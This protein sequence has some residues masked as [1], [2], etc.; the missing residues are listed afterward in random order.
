MRIEEH[1]L[2]GLPPGKVHDLDLRPSGEWVALVR[3]ENDRAVEG[4]QVNELLEGDWI[5]GEGLRVRPPA[6][7]VVPRLRVLAGGSYLLVDDW[8][9]RAPNAWVF[10]EDRVI[11][12]FTIGQ[13]IQYAI[14]VDG[15]IVA[16]Y[17]DI[18]VSRWTSPPAKAL[19]SSR[20]VAISCTAIIHRCRGLS[21]EYAFHLAML[22]RL[23]GQPRGYFFLPYTAFPL[24]HLNLEAF[25]ADARDL[26]MELGASSAIT[27]GEDAV[28]FWGPGYGESQIW[29]FD[30]S[31]RAREFAGSCEFSRRS[32][33]RVRGL[34]GARFLARQ[35][36][37]YRLIHMR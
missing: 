5:V 24:V 23:R 37:R 36:S 34:S 10:N 3:P 28:F 32:E 26:P 14:E 9:S 20:Y 25:E 8:G 31:R 17:G 22:R 12:E 27:A 1:Q 11:S 7:C 4:D 35:D 33:P 21:G 6:H 19:L 16:T 29:R 2:N 18:G 13:D 30:L 15:R